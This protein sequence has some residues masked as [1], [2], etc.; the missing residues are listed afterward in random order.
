MIQTF[1]ATILKFSQKISTN[2]SLL[3]CRLPLRADRRLH[4]HQGSSP[5]HLLERHDSFDPEV[6]TSGPDDDGKLWND[7]TSLL[8]ILES[9]LE[10]II[11]LIYSLVHLFGFF[12]WEWRSK[13]NYKNKSL[14][15]KLST[16]VPWAFSLSVP[17]NNVFLL[18][19]NYSTMV[20]KI[21]ICQILGVPHQIKS[22][23]WLMLLRGS[24]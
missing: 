15:Q 12:V 8:P 13:T 21:R 11:Q 6:F 4:L 19:F 18:S 17:P 23:K 3:A 24:W 9:S 16:C 7:P 1:F 14:D 20:R 22:F 10:K 2:Q 5:D